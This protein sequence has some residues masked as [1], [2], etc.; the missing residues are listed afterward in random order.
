M[1]KKY[2]SAGKLQEYIPAGNGEPSGEYGT[3]KGT[4]NKHIKLDEGKAEPNIIEDN[5]KDLTSKD[6][7]KGE[8]KEKHKQ[9]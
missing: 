7:T 2:N 1:P 9:T 8:T 4:G 6:S 3:N 5:N